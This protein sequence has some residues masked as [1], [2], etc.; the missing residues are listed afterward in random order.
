MSGWAADAA[1][2]VHFTELDASL[3]AWRARGR[4]ADAA[5]VVSALNGINAALA[6]HLPDEE[7][8]AG[9]SEYSVPLYGRGISGGARIRSFGACLTRSRV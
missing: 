9:R 6:V 7:V 4:V 1:M 5:S 8:A 2:L 3:T